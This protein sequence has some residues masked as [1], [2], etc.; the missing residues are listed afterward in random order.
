MN[1]NPRDWLDWLVMLVIGV[2]AVSFF[3]ILA[4][5]LFAGLLV[6]G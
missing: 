1:E 4:G 2:V 5:L 6:K 3:F